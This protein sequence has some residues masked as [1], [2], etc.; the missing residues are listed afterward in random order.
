MWGDYPLLELDSD[1]T[2]GRG[3]MIP[4]TSIQQF[5]ATLASW[6]GVADAELA[7]IF[8]GIGNFDSPKLGFL[9]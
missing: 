6:L 9:G 4:T 1:R 3:R 8:P 2:T 7:T 5:G